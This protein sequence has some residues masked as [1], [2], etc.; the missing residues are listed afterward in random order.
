MS[1]TNNRDTDVINP[2]NAITVAVGVA[3]SGQ[4]AAQ[5]QEGGERALEEIVVTLNTRDTESVFPDR[6]QLLL[7][8]PA[9][10]TAVRSGI[11]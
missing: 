5:A 6:R 3:L 1:S 2:R 8:F 4:Q 9:W 7:E 11:V 10:W